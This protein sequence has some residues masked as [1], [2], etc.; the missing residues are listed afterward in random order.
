MGAYRVVFESI[1]R[2]DLTEQEQNISMAS[3]ISLVQKRYDK[4]KAMMVANSSTQGAYIDRDDAV[5]PMAEGYAISITGAIESKQGRYVIIKNVPNAFVQTQVPHDKE[6]ERIIM[7]IQGALVDTLYKIRP[8]N[9][10]PYVRFD[11]KSGEKI[12]Y[13]RISKALY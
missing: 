12:L 9:D 2:N 4:I 1:S 11:K 13:M 7:K 3:L 8:V 6:D 10:E 5:S